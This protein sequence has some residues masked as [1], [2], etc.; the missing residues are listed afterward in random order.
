M[1]PPLPPRITGLQLIQQQFISHRLGYLPAASN[2]SA[3]PDRLE[4]LHPSLLTARAETPVP[5][6]PVSFTSAR[7]QLQ[8][9]AQKYQVP[10]QGLSPEQLQTVVIQTILRV[11]AREYGI[12]EAIA[13]GVAGNE[14]GW[15]M[16]TNLDK[17]T[18][19]EGRNIRDGVLKS[20]DWGVMQIND[21][22]HGSPRVFPRVKYDLEFNIDYGLSFLARQRQTIR[23][24]LGLGLGDW[25][26]TVAS[27]NLGH[28]P[29][30]AQSLA[31]ARRY[32]TR[33]SA[34]STYT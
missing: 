19:V 26:R 7:Q 11:K 18:V 22:A 6:P 32:V 29:R 31:I 8:Y 2:P 34:H 28:D 24:D 30:T 12:P 4:L 14:S 15:K 5:V 9:L 3:G 16:W 13:L 20:S 23:G 1:F 17:G 21:K 10:T 27:Y 25:D 33:V